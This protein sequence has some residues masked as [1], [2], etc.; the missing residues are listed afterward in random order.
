[1]NAKEAGWFLFRSLTAMTLV[2]GICQAAQAGSP[3]S[4]A[5]MVVTVQSRGDSLGR[6]LQPD[7]LT[8]YQGR[9]L[10]R[11]TS[12][13]RLSGEQSPTELFV[14]V[15]GSAGVETLQTLLP[16]LKA[17]VR[18]LPG[19]TEVGVGSLRSGESPIRQAF[20]DDREKTIDALDAL[21]K[22]PGDSGSSYSAL[23]YLAKHWPSQNPTSRRAVLMPTD[24]RDSN[25]AL[26]ATDPYVE[27]AT[28]NTQ[29][30]GIAVYSIY[31]GTPGSYT[32]SDWITNAAQSNLLALSNATAGHFYSEGLSA[33]VSLTPYLRDLTERLSHQY[34]ITFESRDDAGAQTVKVQT[35]MPGVSI[36]APT[37]LYILRERGEQVAKNVEPSRLMTSA[38]EGQ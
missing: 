3:H 20:T 7:D 19:T 12:L 11:V 34:R 30:A 23:L 31:V 10:R 16:D 6:V 32:A 28:R 22:A 35:A 5:Q 14:Y 38:Q 25:H 18:T 4:V 2:F 17:F 15:D 33:P 36:I 29:I 1:M 21:T 9:S 27:A 13:E 26:S 24:G 37:R 8:V